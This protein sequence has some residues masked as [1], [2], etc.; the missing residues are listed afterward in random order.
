MKPRM[1]KAIAIL[2]G[3]T[4][5]VLSPGMLVNGYVSES[6]NKISHLVV[7]I[8]KFIDHIQQYS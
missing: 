8:V 5:K 6:E 1:Q 3:D 7:H 2:L 4:Q